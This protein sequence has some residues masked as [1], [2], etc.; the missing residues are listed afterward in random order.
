MK[1]K[2]NQELYRDRYLSAGQYYKDE[3]WQG[4]STSSCPERSI[5]KGRYKFKMDLT[6]TY[7][8]SLIE[9][10]KEDI[11]KLYDHVRNNESWAIKKK[12]KWEFEIKHL[13]YLIAC[14]QGKYDQVHA[15]YQ[16]CK[17]KYLEETKC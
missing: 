16:E 12:N 11:E 13:Q 3:V 10:I 8:D 1:Y 2:T 4:P 6:K 5:P 7:E 15:E 9:S 14:R 17:R